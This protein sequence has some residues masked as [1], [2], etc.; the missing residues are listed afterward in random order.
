MDSRQNWLVAVVAVA[1][2]LVMFSLRP[3]RPQISRDEARSST[4]VVT[5]PV[6]EHP[7]E[8]PRRHRLEGVPLRAPHFSPQIQP[9]IALRVQGKYD[10]AVVELEKVL[11]AGD[12]G[13]MPDSLYELARLY[14]IKK[15]FD[16]AKKTFE[17]LL[18]EF[19]GDENRG[20]AE[21]ALQYIR[22]YEKFR[23]EFV[24]FESDIR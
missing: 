6:A 10:E 8:R 18:Q 4:E 2:F 20:N 23:A 7:A 13:V 19:P 14:M 15:D 1:I 11:A 3:Q 12:R 21:R 16:L 24:S 9:V 5:S 17:K 22:N